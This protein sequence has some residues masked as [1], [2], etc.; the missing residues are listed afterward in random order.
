M[1]TLGRDDVLAYIGKPVSSGTP[2]TRK[3]HSFDDV[4]T[5]RV[6]REPYEFSGW[7]PVSYLGI[8]FEYYDVE[9]FVVGERMVSGLHEGQIFRVM[10]VIV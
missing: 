9:Y 4:P 3:R 5:W 2:G 7:H 6:Q 1:F 8:A 10:H